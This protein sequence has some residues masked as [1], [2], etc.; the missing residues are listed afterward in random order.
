[1]TIHSAL[2]GRAAIRVGIAAVAA[3]LL[4]PAAASAATVTVNKQD[5]HN[6][7]VCDPADCTLREAVEDGTNTINLPKGHYTLTLGELALVND[8]IDG[9][10]ARAAII[11]GNTA[12]R[13]L[14]V[15]DGTSTI[16]GVTVTG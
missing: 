7:K 15:V 6:D 2:H 8:E 16:K 3:A 12:S 14:R 13:V 9:A 10:G 1:M 11:D 5:D 4:L